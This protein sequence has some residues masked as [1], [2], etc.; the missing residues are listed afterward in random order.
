MALVASKLLWRLVFLGWLVGWVGFVW[1]F[2]SW[3]QP[4]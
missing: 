1:H 2:V 3:V 4:L